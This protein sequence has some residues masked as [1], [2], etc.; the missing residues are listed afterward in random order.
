MGSEIQLQ[1]EYCELHF[2]LRENM[3]RGLEMKKVIQGKYSLKKMKRC[4]V[5]EEYLSDCDFYLV[6]EAVH[7]VATFIYYFYIMLKLL[8]GFGTTIL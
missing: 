8:L 1:F 7:F 2:L 3:Q 4:R 5:W 6:S